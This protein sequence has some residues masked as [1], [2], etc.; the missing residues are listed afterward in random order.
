MWW[1]TRYGEAQ[2]P[3]SH[4]ISDGHPGVTEGIHASGKYL[5]NVNTPGPV[6]GP[7]DSA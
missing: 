2:R 3:E 6:L 5:L 1:E 4:P 7:V